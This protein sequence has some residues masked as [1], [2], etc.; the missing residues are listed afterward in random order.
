MQDLPTET[1]EFGTTNENFQK[2]NDEVM[3][4]NNY[5]QNDNENVTNTI[6]DNQSNCQNINQNNLN[7]KNRRRPGWDK[8]MDQKE[9][10]LNR[11]KI[12]LTDLGFSNG[13]VQEALQKANYCSEVAFDILYEKGKEKIEKERE[14]AHIQRQTEGVKKEIYDGYDEKDREFIEK[15]VNKYQIS[16]DDAINTFESCEKIYDM[17]EQL[18]SL[19]K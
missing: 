13:D 7:S 6:Q 5:P 14:N 17:T 1:T 16:F 3:S 18:L 8:T 12:D 10:R 19:L 4:P 2:I 11:L 15:I 9:R